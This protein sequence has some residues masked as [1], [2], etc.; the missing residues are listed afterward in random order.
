MADAAGK[1]TISVMPHTGDPC[2]DPACDGHLVVRTTNNRGDGLLVR[3]YRCWKC[4]AKPPNDSVVV[5]AAQVPKRRRHV[6][7]TTKP[8]SVSLSSQRPTATMET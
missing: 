4:K 8:D 5:A 3:Y 6:V 2:V 1:V 7:T